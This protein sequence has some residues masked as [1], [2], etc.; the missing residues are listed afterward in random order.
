MDLAEKGGVS[1]QNSIH[2]V[3]IQ[4]VFFSCYFLLPPLFYVLFQLQAADEHIIFLCIIFALVM[5]SLTGII[6]KK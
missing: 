1:P 2:F 5:D 4:L 3:R 6:L